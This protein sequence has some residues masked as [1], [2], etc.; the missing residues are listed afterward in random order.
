MRVCATNSSSDPIR[1]GSG[2]TIDA[3]P[4]SQQPCTAVISARLV[5]PRMAT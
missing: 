1:I 2:S 4:A 3:A 5:V